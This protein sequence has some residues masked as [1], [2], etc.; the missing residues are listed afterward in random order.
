[1]TIDYKEDILHFD[2]NNLLEISKTRQTPF[3]LYSENIIKNNYNSYSESFGDHSHNICYSVKANSNLSILSLLAKLG[4]G[5]D[6]VSGGELTRVLMAGGDPAKIVFSGVG[7]TQE[8]IIQA[9]DNNI[10]CFNVESKDELNTINKIKYSRVS[11]VRL[12]LL[13][14]VS[15]LLVSCGNKGPLTVPDKNLPEINSE[16]PSLDDTEY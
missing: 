3:Y 4:S 8:E 11:L 14:I 5:F 6:I 12:L 9:L 10:M 2:N 1:M 7:K 15:F 16:Q 13:F